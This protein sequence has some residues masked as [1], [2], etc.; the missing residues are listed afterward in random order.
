MR[1][2]PSPPDT[3][4]EF[5]GAE[6]PGPLTEAVTRGTWNMTLPVWLKQEA[7]P[8]IFVANGQEV[9]PAIGDAPALPFPGGPQASPPTAHGILAVDWQNHFRSSFVF[10]GAGGLR[11][12]QQE[13]NG[14]FTDVTAKTK[15]DQ[16]TLTADYFGVWAADYDADGDLDLIVAPRTGPPLVLRNNG[17]GTFKVMKPFAGVEGVRA[18]V[19][20][21]LDNDGALD[22]SFLDSAGKLHVFANERAGLFRERT[23]PEGIGKSLALAVAVVN[24]E[25]VF[26]LLTLRDD[27]VIQRLSDKDKGKT[28][29]RA[30][31]AR[32]SDFPTGQEPGTY[33]LLTAD[34][35]NNGGIDLLAAGPGGT[36][37]WL[38]DEKGKFAPQ[39]KPQ[40]VN[41]FAT[42][43]LTKDGRLDLLALT[44]EGKLV[45]RVNQ[46]KKNYHWQVLRPRAVN[47]RGEDV[48]PYERMNSFAIGGEAEIRS[49]LLIQK[50]LITAPVLHFGLG[51]QPRATV[52]R[53]L[54]T[55][56]T[57]QNEFNKPGDQAITV[58]QRLTGSCPFLFAGDG[59]QMHFVADFMWGTPLGLH[60]NGQAK[61]NF[62]Q[63][64][65]RVK[66]RGD[67][68][69]SRD[70]LY[71]IRV[72]ADLWET[73]FF[74]HLSLIVVDHPA[75]TEVFAD[76]RFARVPPPPAIHVTGPP[77]PVARATDDQGR[78]VTE[79]VRAV[80]G[81]YLDTFPLGKYQGLARDHYV[82]V[83]LGDDAPT[84]GPLVLLASGWINPTDSSIN[85]AIEQGTPGQTDRPFPLLLE[86]PD[87]K[88]GWK[89]AKDDIGFPAGKNKT[90]L[91]RLDG[92]GG[93]ARV[94]RRFRL[95]TNMEIYWD[96]LRY[97]RVLD[98]S[99]AK[100]QRLAPETAD[101]RYRGIGQLTPGNSTSP[102][103][104][105]GY[106]VVNKRQCWRDLI[107]Y[108]T[109]YGDVRELL[110]KPDDRYVIMNAGD[111][112]ALKFRAPADP[113]AGWK[114]DYVWVSDG[115]TKDGN[116]N[117]RFSKTV[118]PLPYR[119]LKSYDTPPGRLEDDPVY[120]RFPDD[121]K[122]YHTRYVTPAVF[123]QGLRTFRRP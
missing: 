17:D 5:L 61:A 30:E 60:I 21:D 106:G 100:Q 15:L 33:R 26:D 54:W 16:A 88:G 32:W 38:S 34:L 113:P 42:V 69:V 66:I 58:E 52:T 6:S 98:E 25:G 77:R 119:D 102:E 91:I 45:Q 23:L 94:A 29:D 8:V 85:V 11:F 86:I 10:A 14:Q 46:G 7:E 27:G 19:W 122:K 20:A 59:H 108:Y 121:W 107:G 3:G 89:V 90:I 76:E 35:D 63:T 111:E 67:Q 9:R 97:A 37:V 12:Y 68:L 70:G 101:L 2:S 31:V 51:E 96:A 87:G 24:E 49:G 28:W 53:F 39:G 110:A 117:T 40:A 114:R 83:D 104:P 84:E 13:E 118:L 4:L 79:L 72:T 120:Q 81:K 73:H 55:D 57:V 71:D 93:E 116:L 105:L 75:D 41:V 44:K 74:D 78:D 123:E 115:W 50:Q 18:F 82:E 65:E 92:L 80:D 62:A 103:V 109:R 99:Q 22:A 43:D 48:K 47:R 112:I 64:E 36:H 95:R 56:G 1:A